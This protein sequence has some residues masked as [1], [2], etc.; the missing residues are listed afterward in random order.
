M[1]SVFIHKFFNALFG[2]LAKLCAVGTRNQ[3]PK[4]SAD[5]KAIHVIIVCFDTATTASSQYHCY[6]VHFDCSY[7]LSIASEPAPGN[8]FFDRNRPTSLLAAIS[9]MKTN[10]TSCFPPALTTPTCRFLSQRHGVE[11]QRTMTQHRP[12]LSRLSMQKLEASLATIEPHPMYCHQS[13]QAQ[14]QLHY[15]QE[16]PQR[17]SN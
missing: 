1:R 5:R 7:F 2:A 14:A 8:R 13:L 15:R 9:T 4:E 3:K 10:R 12:H 16:V 6:I 17:L 11:K